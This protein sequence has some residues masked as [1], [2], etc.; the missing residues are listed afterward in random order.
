LRADRLADDPGVMFHHQLQQLQRFNV[1]AAEEKRQLV[2]IQM[3]EVLRAVAGNAD[4]QRAVDPRW[5]NPSC[6]S[7]R[8]AG[9]PPSSRCQ[10]SAA[11]G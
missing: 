9:T 3:A 11:A 4:P 8:S 1:R 7:G 5:L 6:A 2:E 10:F